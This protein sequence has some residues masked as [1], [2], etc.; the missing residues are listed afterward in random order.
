MLLSTAT[1]GPTPSLIYC[2]IQLYALGQVVLKIHLLYTDWTIFNATC[3]FSFER[4]LHMLFVLI[5]AAIFQ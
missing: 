2:I 4:M 3:S 1:D 5:V